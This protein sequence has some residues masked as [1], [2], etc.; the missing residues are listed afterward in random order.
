MFEKEYKAKDMSK[1]CY[2]KVWNTLHITGLTQ[3]SHRVYQPWH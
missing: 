3:N 2:W 1:T